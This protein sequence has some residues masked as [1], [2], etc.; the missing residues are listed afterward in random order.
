MIQIKFFMI[1]LLPKQQKKELKHEYEIRL[2]SVIF[3]MIAILGIVA[4][5]LVLPSYFFSK[6]KET[7]VEKNLET[8]NKENPLVKV[9]DLNKINTDINSKIK[10]LDS[11]WSNDPD[12]DVTFKNFLSL[13]PEGISI[14]QILFNENAD[15]NK[16]FEIH[17]QA[18]DREVLQNFKTILEKDEKFKNVDLPISNFVKKTKIDFTLSFSLQ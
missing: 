13:T 16:S 5:A 7:L 2:L 14:S 12:M 10:V 9:E 17:G 11:K 4:T 6:S 8:F 18:S 3:I 15:K 1:N